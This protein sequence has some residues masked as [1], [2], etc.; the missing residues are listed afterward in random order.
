MTEKERQIVRELGGTY[1]AFFIVIGA[2]YMATDWGTVPQWV[3]AVIAATAGIIA[4]YNIHVQRETARK[5]AAIDVFIKTEMDE[6]MIVAY[7]A[8]HSGLE[9]MRRPGVSIGTFCTHPTTRPHYLAIRK[10]L[11][12]HELIAVG[13]AKDVLD[14]DVCYHYWADTLINGYREAKPVIDY[15][16]NRPKNKYTYDDLEKLHTDWADQA[17]KLTR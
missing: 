13:I 16:R 1:L 4:L 7:D 15:V 2:C 11:N 9:E 17:A 3:T 12:V 14:K 10:Y 5:R 6:K 8:F